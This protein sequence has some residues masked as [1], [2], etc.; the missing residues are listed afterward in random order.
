MYDQV[1]PFRIDTL[2]GTLFCAGNL[3]NR[4]IR[5]TATGDFDFYYRVRNTKGPGT[6]GRLV[7][8]SFAGLPLRVAYRADGPGKVDPRVAIRSAAPG[9]AV[10][11][12]LFDTLSCA[13]HQGS[14]FMLIETMAKTFH[15]GGQTRIFSTKG[16]G[17]TLPTVM[18]G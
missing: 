18:P 7:T 4:V 9:A 12:E 13:R 3:E 1:L 6:L 11:F 2:A 14:R 16:T 5:S 10:T 17:E 8:S 15:N